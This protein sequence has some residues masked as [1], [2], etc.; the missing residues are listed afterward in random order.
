MIFFFYYKY[1]ISEQLDRKRRK[2]V[3]SPALANSEKSSITIPLSD[4]YT[5]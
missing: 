1:L 5:V 3:K 2:S 4:Q